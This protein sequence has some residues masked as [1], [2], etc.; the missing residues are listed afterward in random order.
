MWVG[1][2]LPYG[3]AGANMDLVALQ[4]EERVELC[5]II[6]LKVGSLSP[7]GFAVASQQV[8]DYANFMA[9]AFH[10]YALSPDIKTVIVSA[11]HPASI[12]PFGSTTQW[13]LYDIQ[14]DGGVA[15]EA[16]P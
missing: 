11:L 13:I 1:N 9:K 6:E 5:T 8:A 16:A 14:P 2:Y 3:V 4:G 12:R 10:A 7:A 15:F